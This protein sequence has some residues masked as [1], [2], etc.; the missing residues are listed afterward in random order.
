MHV[1]ASLLPEHVRSKVDAQEQFLLRDIQEFHTLLQGGHFDKLAGHHFRTVETYFKLKYTLPHALSVSLSHGLIQYVFSFRPALEKRVKALNTIMLVLKKTRKAFS[2]A[3]EQAKVDWHT[4]LDEWEANFYASPLPLHNAADEYVSQYK[5]ALLKFLAKARPHY[6]LDASLWTHLSADFS[7][8][9][10]EAS[11]KAAAQLSL[12]WPAGAD[13]SALVGPWITLWGSVNSFS[14][15]DFHWLRLFARVVKHQQRR[16]TFDI[17]QWAPHLAFILSKIQ[18]AFNLPSDL[19]ATPSKGKFPTV[20]GGWHGDKSSLYYASKLTV[21]LLEASQTTHTL[22]QQ[23]LSLLTPFYHPSSAGNAASAISD[24][25]YY[26]SAFLSLRL[27]RDK[28]LHRSLLPHTSLVTKLVDLSFLGLYAKSQSVSSKASFTLRNAIAILPSAAPSIVERILHGLDPS[29]VNQTHQA[30]SAISALTVCGP[31]LLRGDLSWTDPYLPLILQWTLPGI[32]P[33]DDAKT[34]RTLQLYSAWLMYMPV[35]DD[36]WR[37]ARASSDVAAA[38]TS[39]AN[40]QLYAP[41]PTASP[42]SVDALWRLGS[43]LETWVLVLLDRLFSLFRQQETESSSA[44]GDKG[45]DTFQIALHTQL[46]LHQLFVQLSPPLYKLALQRVIDFV[47]SSSM[48][49][50]PGKAVAGLVRA[51]TGPDPELAIQKLLLPATAAV[52]HPTTTP[53]DAHLL[54]HLRV[55]DGVVQRATGTSLVPHSALLR[56]VLA[57][58]TG[59]RNPKVV[60]VGCKI[61][62]HTLARLTSTYQPDHSRSLPPAA[63]TDGV[64]C[65]GV[66]SLYIGVTSSWSDVDLVWHEPSEAE[67]L[68]AADLLNVFVVEAGTALLVGTPDDTNSTMTWRTALRGILH[69]VRGAKGILWDRLVVKTKTTS[70]G[71]SPMLMQ[72]IEAIESTL[73]RHPAV[74]DSLLALRV[75]LL[76]TL[77][78]VAAIW[79]DASMVVEDP[80]RTKGLRYIVRILTPLLHPRDAAPPPNTHLYAKWR[81]LS[82]RD[83]A[84]A[85]LHLKKPKTL[86]S[87]PLWP[88]RMMQDRVQVLCSALLTTGSFEWSRAIRSH[89]DWFATP[90]LYADVVVGS[91]NDLLTLA[92]ADDSKTRQVAQAALDGGVLARYSPWLEARLPFLIQ[93]VHTSTNKDQVTGALH[94]LQLGR[95]LRTVWRRWSVMQ[96]L[97]VALCHASEPKLRQWSPDDQIKTQTRA[98]KVFFLVL[99]TR[100]DAADARTVGIEPLVS[101]E[102]Q[103]SHWRHQ[104]MHLACL[105]PWIRQDKTADVNRRLIWPVVLGAVRSDVPQ[106]QHFGRILLSRLL[107]ATT[108]GEGE[109]VPEL[110]FAPDTL[111]ALA[112]DMV[113]NHKSV[114][115]DGH[116]DT[117]R[118]SLG[119]GELFELVQHERF[120]PLCVTSFGQL[121]KDNILRHHVMLVQRLARHAAAQGIDLAARWPLDTLVANMSDERRAALCTA[122]EILVGLATSSTSSFGLGWLQ[123]ILPKLSVPYAT[124]WHDVVLLL[125]HHVPTLPWVPDLIEY[126]LSQVEVSFQ[127][128]DAA[129]GNSTDGV[130]QVRWLMLVQPLLL[131]PSAL[132]TPSVLARMWTVAAA[133]LSHPYESVRE[134]VGA[135]LYK[136]VLASSSSTSSMLEKLVQGMTDGGAAATGVVEPADL[137][138]RKTLL[139]VVATYIHKGDSAHVSAAVLPLLSVVLDTQSYPDPDVARSARA[140]VDA[141]A[142]KLRVQHEDTFTAVLTGLEVALRASWRTRGAAL[143]FVTVL[144]F[145]HGLRRWS[146]PRLQRLIV[147]CL[148]DDKRDVQE[149]AQYALRSFVRTLDDGDVASLATTFRESVAA[150]RK[151]RATKQK[152]LKRHRILVA[153][154]GPDWEVSAKALE[155]LEGATDEMAMDARTVDGCYGMGA[156]V[157]AYPY[158]VPAFVPAVVEELS[159]HLHVTGKGRLSNVPEMVKAVLLE[160]KR[161]HQDSWHQDKLAFTP[162]QLDAIQDSLISPHYYS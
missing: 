67:L 56:R 106:L 34:S 103:Q 94:V 28:A 38:L 146:K 8:P 155:A 62:R 83:V 140:V 87:I 4:P 16:E 46:V 139:H 120:P 149:T 107:K 50:V 148:A 76:Q 88:R 7:R 117:A 119:V 116:A 66:S 114:T 156:L 122:G 53:G 42:A 2:D 43:S 69:A 74:I 160:F 134:Q 27:G 108:I 64:E 115:A 144:N 61:L 105:L 92:L 95:S 78:R 125:T 153:R 82:A 128:G 1:Y 126:V 141:L 143:R 23:L 121:A 48:G 14:E 9:N 72:P 58:A 111:Q 137:N 162:S 93:V 65:G 45:G 55:V 138:A 5:A 101:L 22:L 11:L 57:V 59:H 154:R 25:V 118:W 135:V 75:N 84:S 36:T 104:L 18:Q 35:A 151:A 10:E 157:L 90:D 31:A 41:R 130:G 77:H 96:Q 63:W 80:R 145:H 19:G 123:T 129:D 98:L 37:P 71:P 32:D 70:D 132:A 40:A 21:E 13:A 79:T 89:P 49:L 147:S 73:A 81:K 68:F 158:S 86:A 133:G 20:L 112:K 100:R 15:W 161:T 136:L 26:V 110:V 39:A 44:K 30:P 24:F 91:L 150:A 29:A 127:S 3:S 33:N 159:L 85:A 54:S 52:V 113:A 12:L 142:N 51:A 17:S 152:Q 99:H 47:Q 6:A 124:D 97:L 109:P 102:M 131:L 60:K